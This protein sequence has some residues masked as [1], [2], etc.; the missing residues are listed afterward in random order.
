MLFQP[1]KIALTEIAGMLDKIGQSI[2]EPLADLEI[3]AWKSAEPWHIRIVRR[4]HGSISK[5]GQMG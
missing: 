4:G 5:G 2:Y 1:S 3:T